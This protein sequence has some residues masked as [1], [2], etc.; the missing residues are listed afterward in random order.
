MRNTDLIT[1]KQF[2]NENPI[3]TTAQNYLKNDSLWHTG[4][5]E[6]LRRGGASI[7]SSSD[8]G[9][10]ILDKTKRILMISASSVSAAKELLK[11]K[12]NIKLIVAYQDFLVDYLKEKYSLTFANKCVQAVYLSK[13]FLPLDERFSFAPLS[14]EHLKKIIECYHYE[15][16][17]N[18]KRKI[19]NGEIFGA[20]IGN[21]WVGFV[22]MH[23]EGTM[24]ML[25]VFPEFRRIG[26]GA[27][28]QTFMINRNL[29]LGYIPFG[30]IISNNEAS[31]ALNRKQGL[32]VSEKF[33]YW[34]Y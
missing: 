8:S 11:N 13:D 10:L 5:L 23:D 9:V 12:K 17:S 22:G 20:F 1:S 14:L 16:P 19:K 25:E 32:N 7:V 4:L 31:L 30:H 27:A 34:I 33:L 18:L 21:E 3:E 26:A 28:L 29:S 24:G 15:S 6:V 2:M